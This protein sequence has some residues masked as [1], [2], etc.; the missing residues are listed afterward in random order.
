[1]EIYTKAI[2][3]QTI[4]LQSCHMKLDLWNI[5]IHIIIFIQH[6]GIDY[7]SLGQTV[8]DADESTMNTM[9]V[10][11]LNLSPGLAISSTIVTKKK[12]ITISFK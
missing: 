9:R 12:L 6:I 5:K 11:S 10:R 3:K 7:F 2:H 8:L 1:M 4:L